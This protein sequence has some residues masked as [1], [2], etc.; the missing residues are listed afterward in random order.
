MAPFEGPHLKG[1][2][3]CERVGFADHPVLHG[4][5]NAGIVG[6]AYIALGN[7]PPGRGLGPVGRRTD[8]E[9]LVGLEGVQERTELII[10][11]VGGEGLPERGEHR[12]VSGPEVGPE[13][14]EFGRVPG[15]RRS[16]GTRVDVRHLRLGVIVADVQVDRAPGGDVSE[17]VDQLGPGVADRGDR[18]ATPA[19]GDEDD[20]PVPLRPFEDFDHMGNIV[21]E[22]DSLDAPRFR[23]ERV[24]ILRRLVC[25]GEG[26]RE[27]VARKVDRN[28][29]VPEEGELGLERRKRERIREGPVNKNKCRQIL[30]TSA[31]TR[32]ISGAR[33]SPLGPVFNST[34]AQ[35]CWKNPCPSPR[36]GPATPPP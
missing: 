33:S 6:Q 32:T 16:E 26:R 18:A 9:V 17:P 1:V 35:P 19:V 11:E 23:G 5:R 8:I 21:G 2:V 25:R 29:A 30:H 10:G 4:E 13:H 22:R 20:R 3:G 12:R 28:R 27:P 31:S 14:A 36:P 34:C 7:P 15:D 24:E